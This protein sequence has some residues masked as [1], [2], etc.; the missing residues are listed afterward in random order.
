[1]VGEPAVVEA[2]E[3][4]EYQAGYELGLNRCR[5]AGRTRRGDL[6]VVTSHNTTRD[7]RR[8]AGFLQITIRVSSLKV[9]VPLAAAALPR[10]LVPMDGPA[11]E[12]VLEGGSLTVRARINGKNYR[13]LLRQIEEDGAENGWLR[14]RESPAE[15]RGAFGRGLGDCMAVADPPVGRA[16]MPESFGR[17][18]TAFPVLGGLSGDRADGR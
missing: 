1:V 7:G 6:L 13:K 15:L 3:L 17:A 11:C 10:D 9:T 2:R 8:F 12:P 5:C 14:R 18:A 16:A 4:L